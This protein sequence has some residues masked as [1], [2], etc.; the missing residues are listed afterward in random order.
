MYYYFYFIYSVLHFLFHLN[1]S[2]FLL[3][4]PKAFFSFIIYIYLIWFHLNILVWSVKSSGFS[5]DRTKGSRNRFHFYFTVLSSY[6][7]VRSSS[8]ASSFIG[9]SPADPL[10]D[11]SVPRVNHSIDFHCLQFTHSCART[12]DRR[13]KVK[14]AS[15]ILLRA[16]R[17]TLMRRQ[18]ILM[19]TPQRAMAGKGKRHSRIFNKHEKLLILFMHVQK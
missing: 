19:K 13:F 17:L 3:T 4:W 11:W 16:C 6:T 7:P 12:E 2:A 8:T 10:F 5:S 1:L 15:K 14:M 9:Q 18:N